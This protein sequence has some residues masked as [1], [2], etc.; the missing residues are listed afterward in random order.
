MNELHGWMV[1]IRIII[2]WFWKM[3][4][5]NWPHDAMKPFALYGMGWLIPPQ[6]VAQ[7]IA[8]MDG[9]ALFALQISD[10]PEE[11][12][13]KDCMMM[14]G[15]DSAQAVHGAFVIGI[16]KIA[17]E[18]RNRHTK[19]ILGGK[20]L[21]TDETCDEVGIFFSPLREL[22][23]VEGTVECHPGIRALCAERMPERMAECSA[24]RSITECIA[25]DDMAE[26]QGFCQLCI[27][28][29]S[30]FQINHVLS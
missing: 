12:L 17:D 19:T 5:G 7:E 4:F 11:F 13:V 6:E 15:Q 14:D 9:L 30:V 23:L 28:F 3:P 20:L 8:G 16:G 21:R 2:G 22:Y 26:T 27:L 18:I 24:I 1:S 25:L 10:K 29:R